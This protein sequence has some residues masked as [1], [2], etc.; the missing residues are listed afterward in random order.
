MIHH[1][2]DEGF[3]GGRVLAVEKDACV[4][5]SDEVDDDVE[6]NILT[7]AEALPISLR[8]FRRVTPVSKHSQ[9][10]IISR[11]QDVGVPSPPRM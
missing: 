2:G 5:E 4:R 10:N 1:E 11:W 7:A 6:D 8:V 3:L 9:L